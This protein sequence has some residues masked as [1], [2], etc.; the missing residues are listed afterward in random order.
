MSEPI[1]AAAA[2]DC[3]L[4]TRSSK[5]SPNAEPAKTQRVAPSTLDVFW[6]RMASLFGH[7]WV[8]QYGAAP[9]GVAG[10]TWSAVL[11]GL[12][13]QQIGIGLQALTRIPSDWPPTAPRFRALCLGIPTLAQ[14]KIE[15]RSGNPDPSP[16]ARLLWSYLD[17]YQYRLASVDKA[18]RMIREAYD[19]AVEFV[20]AGGEMPQASEQIA[21]PEPE[22]RKPADP[23]AARRHIDEIAA[24]LGKSEVQRIEINGATAEQ[25]AEAAAEER[26]HVLAPSIRE[27]ER[28]S[29]TIQDDLADLERESEPDFRRL[30]A[31]DR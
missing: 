16:F 14:A 1:G 27:A 21:A 7:S 24:I 20:M 3:A 23:E 22:P 5:L 6:V 10:D 9:D 26:A 29:R 2:A 31:G 25:F 8:S 15:M 30:A 12:T 18:D 19:N 11:A 28:S 4:S 13:T 17:G